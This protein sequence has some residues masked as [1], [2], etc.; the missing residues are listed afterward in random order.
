VWL[1]GL[2]SPGACVTATNSAK[3]AVT[4]RLLLGALRNEAERGFA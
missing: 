4:L 2:N 3:V 1:P